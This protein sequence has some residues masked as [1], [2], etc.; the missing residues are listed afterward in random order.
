MIS[1]RP[2]YS[3]YDLTILNILIQS[4]SV[5]RVITIHGKERT[6]AQ[7]A[8]DTEIFLDG[9]EASLRVSVN[10]ELLPPNLWN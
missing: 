9:S 4:N 5:I 6:A 8:D 1:Y 2:I 7:Y 10:N 3:F